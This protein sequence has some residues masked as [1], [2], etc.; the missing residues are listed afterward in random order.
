MRLTRP[1]LYTS[2]PVSADSKYFACK[3]LNEELKGDPGSA[4]KLEYCNSGNLLMLPQSFGNIYLGETFSCYMSVHND[5]QQTVTAVQVQADLQ[6]GLQKIVLSGQRG[7]YSSFTLLNPGESVDDVIHHESHVLNKG[8]DIDNNTPVL[9]EGGSEEFLS[10][11]VTYGQ[12]S[13]G[14]VVNHVQDNVVKVAVCGFCS[15]FVNFQ[16]QQLTVFG[17]F[18]T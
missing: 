13:S 8:N 7:N 14:T 5:S 18:C 11:T 4:E 16:G 3:L 15:P 9:D 2:C 17:L 10:K 6:I 12:I 1:S